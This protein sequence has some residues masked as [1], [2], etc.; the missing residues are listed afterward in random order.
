M[1]LRDEILAGPLAATL[2]PLVARG[3]DNEIA[4]ALN[5][6]RYTVARPVPRLALLKWAVKYGLLA[7][8]CCASCS[9]L[10]L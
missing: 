8:C 5:L 2:A 10:R 3:A 9:W 1:G 4:A 7:I 6:P